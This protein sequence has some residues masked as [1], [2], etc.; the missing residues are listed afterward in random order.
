M[1]MSGMLQDEKVEL[2]GSS[3]QGELSDSFDYGEQNLEDA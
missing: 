1:T 2:I 3:N